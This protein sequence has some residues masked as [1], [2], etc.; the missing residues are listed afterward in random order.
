[1]KKNKIAHGA[2]RSLSCAS[3]LTLCLVS[4]LVPRPVSAAPVALAPI[5]SGVFANGN[6]ANSHW[7]QVQD[8]W[9]GPSD[10]SQA[11]SGISSL[12]DA[13]AALALVSDDAGFLRGADAVMST[14][15]AGNDRFNQGHAAL[16]GAANMPPL[17]ASGD[18]LQENYA[19]HVWG[20]LAVPTAGEYNFGVL[21]D[22]GFAFTLWGSQCIAKH[23]PRRAQSPRPVGIRFRYQHAAG[24]L[25]FR[26]GGLQPPG[27][28]SAESG[29]VVRPHDIQFRNHSAGQFVHRCAGSPPR[30]RVAVRFGVT[31]TDWC[32]AA[33][34]MSDTHPAEYGLGLF[35]PYVN[36]A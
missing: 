24:P 14:I 7:V 13:T 36:Y 10:F 26:S 27:S 19:A 8:G 35:R 21:S 29:L 5:V 9:Q 18:S 11:Y 12:Q 30:R 34:G 22:D 32:R 4:G 23:V 6:G 16:W 28:R 15:D 3:L 20:Y 17:F 2:C 33:Q 31:R 25:S 1:M